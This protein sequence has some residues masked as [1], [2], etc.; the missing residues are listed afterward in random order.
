MTVFAFVE[1][2]PFRRAGSKITFPHCL[3]EL[4]LIQ[5]FA[6]VFIPVI[7]SCSHLHSAVMICRYFFHPMYS[8]TLTLL[9]IACCLLCSCWT[10]RS[11]N[12]DVNMGG[13][14]VKL[15]TIDVTSSTSRTQHCCHGQCGRVAMWRCDVTM[16]PEVDGKVPILTHCVIELFA[17]KIWHSLLRPYDDSCTKFYE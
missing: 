1:G 10:F 6:T 15:F 12:T 9:D 8:R 13:G 7:N 4:W 2:F 11:D 5:C 14:V 3:E 16:A 17:G